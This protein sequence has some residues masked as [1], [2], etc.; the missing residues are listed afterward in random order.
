MT[1]EQFGDLGD[2]KTR[3]RTSDTSSSTSRRRLREQPT[4]RRAD[5][6]VRP[7]GAGGRLPSL[8]PSSLSKRRSSA[9]KDEIALG[10]DRSD[11]PERDTKIA[12]LRPTITPPTG[13]VRTR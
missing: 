3:A 12:S 4:L 10:G 8:P 5:G 1:K 6:R 2:P 11:A 13:F 7:E 9:L